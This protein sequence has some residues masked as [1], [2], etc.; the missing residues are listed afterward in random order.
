M[1]RQKKEKTHIRK[2]GKIGKQEYSS[3]YLTLPIDLVREFGWKNGQKLT[4]K[5]GNNKSV[6]IET[7]ASSKI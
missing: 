6:V 4:V 5:K 1:A 3:F 7:G 2:L